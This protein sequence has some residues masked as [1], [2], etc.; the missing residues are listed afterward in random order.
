MKKIFTLFIGIVMAISMTQSQNYWNQY[1]IDQNFDG[2]LA[3]PT[4]WTYLNGTTAVFGRGGGASY[5]DGIKI[6]GT[7]SGNRGGEV[8]F[9]LVADSST[10]YVDVDLMVNKSTVNYRNTFQ[11]YLLGSNSANVNKNDG[12]AFADVIAGI[13]WVGSSG[14]FHVWNKDIHGPVP[15]ENPDS[16]I[17]VFGTGQY[18]SFRRAGANVA[19]TDSFNLNTIT[20]MNRVYG[21]WYNLN[22][23]LNFATKKLDLTIT[24]RDSAHIT[25]TITD[26]DFIT[27]TTTDFVSFGMVN[28]RASNQGNASNGDID[29]T[30]DN[31]KV[32][33]KVKSLGLANVTVN[34]LDQDG[35]VAKTARVAADQEIGMK[36]GLS[37]DDKTSFTANDFYYAYDVANTTD[38]LLVTE[39]GI[40]ITA[41][42]KKTA[43]TAGPYTWKGTSSQNWNEIDP[44]FTT[45]GTNELGFQN[46]NG[47]I[48]SDAASPI[49]DIL[50]NNLV[51]LGDAD[52]V[53]DAPGYSV[54]GLGGVSGTGNIQVNATTKLGLIN[55]MSGVVYLNKDTLTVS[56]ADLATKYMVKDGTTLT[57]SVS[58]SAPIQGTGGTFTL[59]PSVNSYSSPIKGMQVVNYPLSVKG[60]VSST[61]I[62]GMPR[63]ISTL[64]SL[65]SLKVTSTTGDTVT[66]DNYYISYKYNSIDLGKKVRMTYSQNPNTDASTVVE[67]GE[68]TGADSSMLVGAKLRKM[69]YRVGHLNTDAVFAGV[70]KPIVVDAWAARADFD[71]AKVGKGKWTLAGKSADF[72]GSVKVLDGTL[73]VND[74]LCNM[75][76]EYTYGVAPTTTVV[77]KRITE[78]TVADT[79]TLAGNGFIGANVVNQNGTIT[80]NLTIGGTLNMKADVGLGGATTIIYVSSTGAQKI[81]V[82]GDLYYGGKLIVRKEEG[83]NPSAGEFQIFEFANFVESGLYGFNSIELPSENWTF[84]YETGILT[85]AG[86]D[87]VGVE[88]VDFSKTIQSKEYFDITGKQVTKYHKGFVLIKVNYTDGTSNVV[89]SYIKN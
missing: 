47:V 48:L 37:V 5:V 51:N 71:I 50:L 7:G 75:I 20:D 89:K 60:T 61:A 22:F 46:G 79:A 69:T 17:P 9:P 42:F 53:I 4:G 29:A 59:K 49:K 26:L 54:T 23:K 76:G 11:F 40:S 78:V 87:A 30:V 3:M 43:V 12:T 57:S 27:P 28:N 80:G 21:I 1:L 35:N 8:K 41:K 31:F 25:Q 10:I 85:Y 77:P 74:T 73:E 2:L 6:A 44:N 34:Y 38:S 70:M 81:K 86:G 55:K 56:K 82:V 66:F 13:Y 24:Q 18:P 84:D 32:Y 15:V 14:K 72:F 63:M 68:L 52:L 58:L 62:S 39:G 64:D 65:T 67:I 83:A 33:Q 16:I 88:T 36:F 45:N 19:A